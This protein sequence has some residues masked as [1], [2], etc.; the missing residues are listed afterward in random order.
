VKNFLL[1]PYLLSACGGECD[2]KTQGICVYTQELEVIEEDVFL[3]VE[4]MKETLL[5][6]FRKVPKLKRMFK[7]NGVNVTFTKEPLYIDCEHIE[8]GVYT[9]TPIGGRIH[10][11][12]DII[13]R[14][15]KCLARTALA[16][17]LLHVVEYHML[18]V[19]DPLGYR[20][21]P[22]QLPFFNDNARDRTTSIESR[23]K[24]KGKEQYQSCQEN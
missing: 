11:K 7:R 3:L 15:K 6:D 22:H 5:E 18:N 21:S 1:I 17:E 10:A 23:I 12:K 8:N 9:C 4:I 16:H 24:T 20:G 2:F 14:W 13:L 19:G